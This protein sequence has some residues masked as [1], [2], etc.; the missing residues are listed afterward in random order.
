LFGFGRGLSRIEFEGLQ[1]NMSESTDRMIE[2]AQAVMTGLEQGYIEYNGKVIKQP[3]ARI[4]PEPVKSFRNRIYA[5]SISPSSAPIMARLGVGVSIIPQKPWDVHI[6]DLKTYEKIFRETHGYNPPKPIIT[7]YTVCHSDAGKAKDMAAKYIGGYWRE[8]VKHYEMNGE[9]F[10]N[11]TG[12]EY[13]ANVAAKLQAEGADGLTDFFMDLQVYGTPQQC[14]DRIKDIYDKSHRCGS[15][16]AFKFGG[17]PY[18]EARASMRLFAKEVMSELRKL[19]PDPLFNTE[20]AAP[21]AFMA[22]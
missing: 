1:L 7:S 22:A 12:Y 10:A 9:H 13:Y 20:P 16:S 14:Y 2:T 17:M 4:R 18:E 21:P 8:V 3:K 5:P 6:A 11:T 19:G 15:I